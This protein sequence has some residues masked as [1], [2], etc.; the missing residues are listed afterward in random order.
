MAGTV[1]FSMW[2]IHD[3][4]SSGVDS[5]SRVTV[6]VVYVN[7]SGFWHWYLP[8]DWPDC[9]IVVPWHPVELPSGMTRNRNRYL[10][11]HGDGFVKLRV[12]GR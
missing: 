3:E 2:S 4:A 5:S 9:R 10:N 7:T 1:S 12:S 11:I 6:P 8:E